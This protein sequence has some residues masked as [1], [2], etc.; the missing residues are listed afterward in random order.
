MTGLFNSSIAI[1]TQSGSSAFGGW[2][3]IFSKERLEGVEVTV[4]DLA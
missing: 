3:G 2:A 4:Y 1:Q